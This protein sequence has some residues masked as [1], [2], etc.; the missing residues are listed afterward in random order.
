MRELPRLEIE[1]CKLLARHDAGGDLGDRQADHLGDERHG[2]RGARIDLEDIDNIILHRELHVHQADD[3]EGKGQCPCLRF[4]FPDDGGLQRIGRQRAGAVTGM[5]ARFLDM[6]HDAGDEH[7]LAVGD[8]VDIDFNG[9][10]EIGVD[11][12][13]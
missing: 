1:A 12:H 7:I 2:A 8:A 6:F 4:Q 9:V 10:G 3:L 11:E 13:R 5:D